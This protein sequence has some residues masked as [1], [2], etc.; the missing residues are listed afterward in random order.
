MEWLG[1]E[2]AA[3]FDHDFAIYRHG[4]KRSRAFEIVR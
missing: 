4:P 1:R 3:S 2:H